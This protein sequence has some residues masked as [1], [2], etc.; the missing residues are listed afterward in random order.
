MIA[1][2][3]VLESWSETPSVHSVRFEKPKAFKFLPVQFCGLELQTRDGSIEYSMSLA[4]SP[5]RDYLEF[6]A[7]LSG[8][9]WKRAFAGLRPGDEAEVDGPY[10]HFVLDEKRP[11]VFVAGGIGITPLKGMIEY[12]TDQGLSIP[13]SLLYSNRDVEEIAYR[14][15]LDALAK[16]NPHLR[17]NYT[18][19][20]PGPGPWKG[21]T[22]RI[23][24]TMLTTAAKGLKDP[25]FYLC[26]KPGL[27]AGA[28]QTLLAMDVAQDRLRWEQFWGYE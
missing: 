12:A 13:L 7:R 19:T 23:D 1:R 18:L 14:K 17:L 25:V 26:G 3:R 5:T 4:C 22:G 15:D 28:G 6:G 9:P 24:P 10:G 27:V 16:A 11:A 2:V 20:R 8:T 21:L